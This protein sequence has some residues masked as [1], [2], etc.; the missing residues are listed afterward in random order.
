VESPPI[1]L[2]HPEIMNAVGKIGSSDVLVTIEESDLA[3]LKQGQSRLGSFSEGLTNLV[4]GIGVSVTAQHYLFP[5][6]HITATLR[7]SLELTII[8]TAVGFARGY[9]LRRMF[10]TLSKR[11]LNAEIPATMRPGG[12]LKF[13]NN[14]G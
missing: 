6:Y 2:N 7:T 12:E 4:A 9:V 11:R 13:A 10:N 1:I 5:L 14:Q 3:R 8:L